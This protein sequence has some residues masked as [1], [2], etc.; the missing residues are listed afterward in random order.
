MEEDELLNKDLGWNHGRYRHVEIPS[1]ELTDEDVESDS[2]SEP[3]SSM[4]WRRTYK[5]RWQAASVSAPLLDSQDDLTPDIAETEAIVE[6]AQSEKLTPSP[7][8]I[9]PAQSISSLQKEQGNI[10]VRND[11]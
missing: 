6:A 10:Y 2:T 8:E 7:I 3:E 1:A 9:W 11:D 5:K 4:S